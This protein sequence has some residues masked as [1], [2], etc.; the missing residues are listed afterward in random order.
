MEP[1]EDKDNTG[2]SSKKNVYL[3]V[4]VAEDPS[5]LEGQVL[6]NRFLIS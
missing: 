2:S 6:K 3:E 4:I 5:E 1:D